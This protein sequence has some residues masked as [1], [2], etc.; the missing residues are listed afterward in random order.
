MVF[1]IIALLIT[2]IAVTLHI[3]APS[4]QEQ[5]DDQSTAHLRASQDAERAE[6]RQDRLANEL[7]ECRRNSAQL[8]EE[9]NQL[10]LKITQLEIRNNTTIDP[11]DGAVAEGLEQDGK[12]IGEWTEKYASGALKSRGSYLL[13]KQ[14]GL[15]E[16]WDEKG[17]KTMKGMFANGQ[18]EGPWL[19]FD[20]DRNLV[21]EVVYVNGIP[22]EATYK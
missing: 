6:S 15:W 12:R 18:R 1:L 8:S 7:E 5:A 3:V 10:K 9:L 13:D 2:G 21:T 17:N 14:I 22:T 4:Q 11:L 16:Y 19:V 20:H